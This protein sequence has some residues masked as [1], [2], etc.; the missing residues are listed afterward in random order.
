ME[1]VMKHGNDV[2]HVCDK[3][4]LSGDEGLDLWNDL[5][6]LFFFGHGMNSITAAKLLLFLYLCK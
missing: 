3:V 5:L 1:G 2:G 4:G 6:I